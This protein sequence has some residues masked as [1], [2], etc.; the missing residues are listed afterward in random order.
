[1]AIEER[2]VVTSV[3]V[4]VGNHGRC[5]ALSGHERLSGIDV[6][7]IIVGLPERRTGRAHK[8]LLIASF[9]VID[10]GLAGSRLLD[11]QKLLLLTLVSILVSNS[12][13]RRSPTPNE[14]QGVAFTFLTIL[15]V[16]G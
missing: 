16:A 6:R 3:G 12:A 15:N 1:M 5:C 10:S 8:L 2:L 13:H 7:V 9:G 11:A 4:I 14:L